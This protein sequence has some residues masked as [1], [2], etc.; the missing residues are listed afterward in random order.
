MIQIHDIWEGD[1]QKW[2]FIDRLPFEEVTCRYNS[3]PRPCRNPHTERK[4][5]VSNWAFIGYF[6]IAS[7]NPVFNTV[8]NLF[9]FFSFQSYHFQNNRATR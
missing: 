9:R 4:E 7:N 1:G 6:E 8:W 5:R 3:S 2:G